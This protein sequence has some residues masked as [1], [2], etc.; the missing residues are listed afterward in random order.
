MVSGRFLFV[1]WSGGGNTAPTYPMVRELV[2]RGHAVTIL[3]QSVQSETARA[4]GARFAPLGV[5]DWTTGKSLEDESDVFFELLFGPAVGAAVVERI[6]QDPPDVIVVDCMLAS[7]LAAAERSGIPSAAIVHVLY[8]QLIHGTMG[9]LWTAMMPMIN[10]TRTGLGLPPV[11]SPG[12]LLDPMSV[13]LVACPREFDLAPPALP[14]N[15]RYVGAILDDPPPLGMKS[16]WRS[17]GGELRVLV[18]FST[19]CQHQEEPLLRVAA[20]LAGLPVQAVITTGLAV[21]P[22]AIDAA[23]NVALHRYIPHRALLPDCALVVTHAGLGAVMA[24]LAHGVP[25]V[26]MPMGRE[27]HDNAARVAACGAGT[28]LAADAAVTEIRHTIQAM[29]GAPDY[30]AAATQMASVIARQNGRETA[31]KELETLVRAT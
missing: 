21:D 14:P 16:P 7:G 4:L 10:A 13:A 8:N 25:L 9:A 15:I 3:G 12:A 20:A 31:V 17:P 18:A 26:C 5:P 29:L 22:A 27:Q 11:D 24:S 1:T 23:P 30:R 2:G 28:V 6:K 19:T